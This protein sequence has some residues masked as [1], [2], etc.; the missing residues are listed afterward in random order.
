MECKMK[1]TYESKG[2]IVEVEIHEHATLDEVLEGMQ[3]FLRACGYVIPYDEAL[4][5]EKIDA[6]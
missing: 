1:L 5:L 4:T 6:H 3:N 2:D